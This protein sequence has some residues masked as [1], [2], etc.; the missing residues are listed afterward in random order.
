MNRK[1]VSKERSSLRIRCD[2]HVPVGRR[3]LATSTYV[4]KEQR[5]N[6]CDLPPRPFGKYSCDLHL[7]C[8]V[9]KQQRSVVTSNYGRKEQRCNPLRHPRTTCGEDS[10]D[11]E[12]ERGGCGKYSC[13]VSTHDVVV[14]RRRTGT[15]D[16][17]C[18]QSECLVRCSRYVLLF[19]TQ[20]EGEMLRAHSHWH[21]LK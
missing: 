11:Q 6:P 4:R 7:L 8:K 1:S 9:R 14:R 16:W 12:I 2:L 10:W 18:R 15:A 13:E 5:S 20:A 19:R 21:Y 3:T 17:K